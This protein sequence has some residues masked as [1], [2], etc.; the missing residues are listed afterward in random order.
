MGE[1]FRKPTGL[2]LMEDK[3]IAGGMLLREF[4]AYLYRLSWPYGYCETWQPGTH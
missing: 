4:R 2:Y 1:Q 3:M